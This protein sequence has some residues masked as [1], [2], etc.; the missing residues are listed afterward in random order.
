MSDDL[1]PCPFCGNEVELRS[2]GKRPTG[3]VAQ[4]VCFSC[5]AAVSSMVFCETQRMADESA[6]ASWNRRDGMVYRR[7]VRACRNLRTPG[8]QPGGF[9]CSECGASFAQNARFSFCPRC[10]ARVVSE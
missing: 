3:Y 10:G 5:N 6:V 7:T 9:E 8:C 4:V 1:R 2:C